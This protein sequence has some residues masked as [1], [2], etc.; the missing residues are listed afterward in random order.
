M[1]QCEWFVGVHVMRRHV[2]LIDVH[3][4]FILFTS[5]HHSIIINMTFKSLRKAASSFFL[6]NKSTVSCSGSNGGTTPLLHLSVD[7]VRPAAMHLGRSSSLNTTWPVIRIEDVNGDVLT[8]T[9]NQGEEGE[10]H[11]V[12]EQKRRG[13]EGWAEE[14]WRHE[15]MYPPPKLDDE[16]HVIEVKTGY[17]LTSRRRLALWNRGWVNLDTWLEDEIKKMDEDPE[18]QPMGCGL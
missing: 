4:F 17:I 13:S 14:I 9:E 7:T 2:S 18:Y 12:N 3:C 5:Y 8:M 1:G 11:G 16:E 15:Q 6:S 10:L